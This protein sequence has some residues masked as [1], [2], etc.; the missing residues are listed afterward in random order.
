RLNVRYKDAEGKKHYVH[1]LNGT[2]LAISRV[3]IALLENG[4]DAEGRVRI[5][6]AL[7]PFC[8]FEYLYP[9]VL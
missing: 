9:R 4:Q 1:M 5:P 2:A 8:G 7:V 6:Q 3:L